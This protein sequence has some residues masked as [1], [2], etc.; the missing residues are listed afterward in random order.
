MSAAARIAL[1]P[2]GIDGLFLPSTPG[3]ELALLVERGRPEQRW[4]ESFAPERVIPYQLSAGRPLQELTTGEALHAS[5][6]AQAMRTAGA[7]TLFL[8]GSR[9]ADIDVWAR[10]SG[11][12]LAAARGSWARALEHKIRFD[13]LLARER[14]TRPRGVSGRAGRLDPLP[15]A[16]AAVAQKPD[17]MGGEG[18]F[19]LTPGQPLRALIAAGALRADEPC[20]VREF[21]AGRPLGITLL[22]AHELVALSALRLQCYYPALPGAP[23]RMFAGIQWLPR[24]AL[25]ARLVR[26]IDALFLTLARSLHRQGYR[27]FAN[28]DFICD[29]DDRVHVIECNPRPSAA[30]PAL[31]VW[32]QLISDLPLGELYLDA[33]LTRARSA[34]RLHSLGLPR[35]EFAGATLD[36]AADPAGVRAR[37]VRRAVQSGVYRFGRAGLAY[38]DPDPRLLG[39][40]GN[41]F[42]YCSVRRGERYAGDATLV[43]VLS[44]VTLYDRHGRLNSNGRAVLAAFEVT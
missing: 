29:S 42:A 19:F 37:R 33:V 12:R 20:L 31:L 41:L 3:R 16:G 44:A 1:F 9:G 39:V 6:I 5:D 26:R 18:T 15:F 27:G 22:I 17:S 13:A 38:V 10:A 2:R 21:V 40:R 8:H 24:G 4:G 28:L 43:N 11:M 23:S 35:A 14:I 30:T 36:I 34:K 32:P 7:R 25:S